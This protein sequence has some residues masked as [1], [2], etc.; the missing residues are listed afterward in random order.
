MNA[1]F[2]IGDPDVIT[3]NNRIIRSFRDGESALTIDYTGPLGHHRQITTNVNSTTFPLTNELFNPNIWENGTFDETTGT[4]RT[5]Q[6]GFGGWQYD[7]IDL[8]DYKYI[9]ARIASNTASVDFRLFDETSYW[10]SPASYS[11]GSNNEVVVVLEYARKGNGAFLNSKNI[12]IAGFWSNGS[13]P[14]VIDTVFVSNSSEFDPPR[15]LVN[16]IGGIQTFDLAGFEY[17]P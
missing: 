10:S 17:D 9:V 16:G 11:F 8:S 6:W 4:L 12:Y 15:I 14:F 2:T 1:E 3:V 13:N 5:G 7:G